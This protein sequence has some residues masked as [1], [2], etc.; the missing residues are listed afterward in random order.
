MCNEAM[1]HCQRAT[2]PE[3]IHS[4]RRQI[5]NIQ[6]AMMVPSVA[7]PEIVQPAA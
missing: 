5:A 2:P 4:G 1:L 7:S 6:T 3:A